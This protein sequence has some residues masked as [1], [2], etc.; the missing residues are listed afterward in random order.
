MRHTGL[1]LTPCMLDLAKAPSILQ[2]EEF[3]SSINVPKSLKIFE[4]VELVS[5]M[6][7]IPSEYL[8]LYT[9]TLT[10]P[11]RPLTRFNHKILLIDHSQYSQ[12][13]LDLTE[14]GAS[15]KY[16]YLYFEIKQEFMKV[17][18]SV[19]VFEKNQTPEDG[20]IDIT[21]DKRESDIIHY[22]KNNY[23]TFKHNVDVT[24]VNSNELQQD[25]EMMEVDNDTTNLNENGDANGGPNG[26]DPNLEKLLFFKFL[27]FRTGDIEVGDIIPVKLNDIESMLNNLDVT[28]MVSKFMPDLNI[29][30]NFVD[31]SLEFSIFPPNYIRDTMTNSIKSYNQESQRTDQEQQQKAAEEGENEPESQVKVVQTIDLEVDHL[32]INT[33]KTIKQTLLSKISLLKF[34]NENCSDHAI[35]YINLQFPDRPD[36]FYSSSLEMKIIDS[37]N[38]I[39]LAISYDGL[40][41][42]SH[43]KYK[44]CLTDSEDEIKNKIFEYTKQSGLLPEILKEPL[45][46]KYLDKQ[47][48]LLNK[49]QFIESLTPEN[50]NF[51]CLKTNNY[52]DNSFPIIKYITKSFINRLKV[53]INQVPFSESDSFSTLSLV[54]FDIGNN[55][56]GKV[57]ICLPNHVKSC[58]DTLLYLEDNVIAN[59]YQNIPLKNFYFVIQNPESFYAYEQFDNK[60]DY[61]TKYQNNNLVIEYRLQPYSDED[62]ELIESNTRN[63]IFVAFCK[64][65]LSAAC[66]PIIIYPHQDSTVLQTKQMLL[67]KMK[68][69]E[70]LK[71][72]DLTLTKLKFYSYSLE[73]YKPVKDVLLL[74]NKDESLMSNFWRNKTKN[75]LVELSSPENP[76]SG[77]SMILL[78]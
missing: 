50:I 15:I 55:P 47:K 39:Y 74:S 7:N 32:K 65:D 59:Y 5:K 71:N 51:Y 36:H 58:A 34:L 57:H 44:F 48:N 35:I 42:Q 14:S 43:T 19:S 45:E 1:G 2:N 56:I 22:P 72:E 10:D 25:H 69:I 9:Y 13:M 62:V 52:L 27:N 20:E 61:L 30:K 29:N 67:D 60:S 38:V 73:R 3:Q 53:Y 33:L 37:Y 28:E 18:P 31:L 40:D 21:M 6:T 41:V 46:V 11:L 8:L 76:D 78:N 68:N 49:E 54:I 23:Y 70:K 63:K 17:N 4:L 24:P 16:I 64:R 77:G 75:L 26:A 66:D 12:R